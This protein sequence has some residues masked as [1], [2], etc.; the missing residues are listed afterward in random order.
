MSDHGLSANIE[1]VGVGSAN[2]AQKAS[3]VDQKLQTGKWTSVEIFE[4]SIANIN[5]IGAMI[6]S[7]YPTVFFLKNH[8]QAE[9]ILRKTIYNLLKELFCI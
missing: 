7:K 1:I 5:A 8:I 9:G 4:D 3:Y 6:K 2:P